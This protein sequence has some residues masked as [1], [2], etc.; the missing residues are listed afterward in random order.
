MKQIIVATDFSSL[1]E[2]AVEYAAQFAKDIDANILLF[3]SY[4][5]PTVVTE[6]AVIVIPPNE[7]QKEKEEVL[8]DHA[9]KLA[10]KWGVEV[11]YSLKMGNASDE[12]LEE[13]KNASY[14]VMGMYNAG[15]LARAFMGSTAISVIKKSV[16]P[17]LL[18]PENVS[19]KKPE[20]IAFASDYNSK[21]DLLALNPLKQLIELFH[22]RL[23]VMNIK[24][25]TT[26][27]SIEEKATAV[28][29]DRKLS[30]IDHSYH[31]MESED[32]VEGIMEFI[33]DKKADMIVVIP[34]KYNLFERLS[35]K[36]AT[37][38]LAFQSPIPFL[39]LPDIKE[40]SEI[41]K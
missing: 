14:I 27:V 25:R 20:K 17:V 24:E 9:K 33:N 19:Y 32:P 28:K 39:A 7:L 22:S 35:H 4:Q 23:L 31:F 30:D 29:M 13:A 5:I 10:L 38:K 12:I 16:I 40:D 41:S 18:I 11:N 8:K 1:S 26:E 2:N 37:K 36:S 6:A 3:H 21:T 15:K 34:H